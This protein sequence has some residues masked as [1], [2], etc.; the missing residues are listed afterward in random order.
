VKAYKY[1]RIVLAVSICVVLLSLPLINA[2]SAAE[3]DTPVDCGVWANNPFKSGSVVKGKGIVSCA[4]NH[5]SIRVVVDVWDGVG[6]PGYAEKTCYN[7]NYCDATAQ[8]QYTPGRSWIT[9][10]SGY[11]GGWQGYYQTNWIYIP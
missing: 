11:V 10:T 1:S 7:A 9:R 8:K 6:S 5:A 4:T 3:P 2:L